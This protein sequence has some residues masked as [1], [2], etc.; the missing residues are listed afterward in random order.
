MIHQ[1]ISII[2]DDGHCIEEIKKQFRTE[3]AFKNHEKIIFGVEW[4]LIQIVG[5]TLLWGMIQFDRFGSD[6]MKRRII[7]Q[8]KLLLPSN[9]ENVYFLAS[10]Y[11]QKF[12]YFSC[13]QLAA[14]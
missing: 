6:P 12:I 5:N 13:T 2:L 4:A 1:N 11:G 7:D 3:I 8:V 14:S 10:I 9:I